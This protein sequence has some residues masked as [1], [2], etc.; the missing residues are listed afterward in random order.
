MDVT[1][2]I[3]TVPLLHFIIK[4]SP[5]S[6]SAHLINLDFS[7]GLP[8]HRTFSAINSSFILIL[9]APFDSIAVSITPID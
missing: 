5:G 8:D 1:F 6:I 2:E 9:A 7:L 4:V 3:F